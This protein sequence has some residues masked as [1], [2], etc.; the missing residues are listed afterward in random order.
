MHKILP[1]CLI[2]ILIISGNGI[3]GEIHQNM[4]YKAPDTLL[5]S[6]L[7]DEAGHNLLQESM[8]TGSHILLR[9]RSIYCSH[10]RQQ[11]LDLAA[12]SAFL[13]QYKIHL[14]IISPESAIQQEYFHKK[15]AL[16]PFIHFIPDENNK[17][18]AALQAS[19]PNILRTVNG[20]NPP[21][22]ELHAAIVL[23]DKR[24]VAAYFSETAYMGIET[25]LLQA[26][27]TAMA[28]TE[29]EN[30]FLQEYI[31]GPVQIIPVLQA[32]DGVNEP[33]DLDFNP[34]PLSYGDLW[35][36]NSREA[37]NTVLIVNNTGRAGQKTEE[38]R[39]AAAGHFMW[40]TQAL[41]FGQN[42][43]FAT[44]QNGSPSD[45]TSEKDLYMF[46]GP[47]LWTSDTAVFAR[48]NFLGSHLDML[49]QSPFNLGIA[50]EKDNIYWVSDAKYMDICRYDFRNPHEIGGTDH[51]DGQIFRYPGITITPG[52]WG[53]PAHLA[54]DKQS[55]W[56]Y[57]VDPG[58]SRILRM[59]M[60]SGTRG[61]E[62]T[63]PPPSSERLNLFVQM[64]K[65]EWE[66]LIE[67]GLQKPCGIEI[68]N[69]I[70]MVGDYAT[71]I[72]HFYDI[73]GSKPIEIKQIATQA[74]GL[75]GIALSPD[76]KIWFC[77]RL[78]NSINR[79]DAGSAMAISMQNNGVI[80]A[81]PDSAYTV[82]FSISNPDSLARQIYAMAESGMALNDWTIQANFTKDDLI[83]PANST[84]KAQ[85]YTAGW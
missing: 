22:N 24:P 72:I 47:T 38:R 82:E 58:K 35:A 70:L 45:S 46:M 41:A 19:G 14:W 54:A 81:A 63:P 77:D 55:G 1:F 66:V 3:A 27:P 15:N 28:S 39:D 18:A 68:K 60:N 12:R 6:G 71:G 49:H 37:G 73:T 64:D 40:R 44:A 85:F 29:S 17:L 8:A 30:T 59:K 26:A 56:L 13:E 10:C 80:I 61:N 23:K 2:I 78:S 84:K 76:N 4:L 5:Q 83:I 33:M 57:I 34:S 62:L 31:K 67:K 25:L 36:V 53:I 43:T 16:K 79:I 48:M 69:G 75:T 20:V 11:I 65:P 74:K 7:F 9:V 50:H 32:A 52:E 21:D 42:G 51:R